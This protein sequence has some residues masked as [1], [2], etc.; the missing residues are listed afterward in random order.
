[1]A[2]DAGRDPRSL[3]ITA[4]W[5]AVT[6]GWAVPDRA[7]LDEVSGS[8]A[9]RLICGVPPSGPDVALRWLDDY[10]RLINR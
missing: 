3:D 2:Q 6:D 9:D 1:M 8:G 7:V 5:A 10:A 4:I